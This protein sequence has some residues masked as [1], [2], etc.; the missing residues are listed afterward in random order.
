[1]FIVESES[2]EKILEMA[3]FTWKQNYARWTII[4]HLSIS[5][6]CIVNKLHHTSKT[7]TK[8]ENLLQLHLKI[9]LLLI[10][11]EMLDFAGSRRHISYETN[12]LL[13]HY[14]KYKLFM[15]IDII[16]GF[17]LLKYIMNVVNIFKLMVLTIWFR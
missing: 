13:P 6:C 9:H 17:I 3:L 1:M 7:S 8:A 11:N 15:L 12:S 14:L 10:R 2:I 4:H 16:T 5:I